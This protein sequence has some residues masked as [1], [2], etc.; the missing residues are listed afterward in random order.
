MAP[1]E[2]SGF[3]PVAAFSRSA[4]ISRKVGS[5]VYWSMPSPCAN[6]SEPRFRSCG[7][8]PSMVVSRVRTSAPAPIFSARETRLSTSRSSVDQ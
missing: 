2:I 5:E 3:S 6:G 7:R 1:T 8:H 4:T